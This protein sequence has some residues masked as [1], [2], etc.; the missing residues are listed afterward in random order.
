MCRHRPA[1]T[2]TNRNVPKARPTKTRSESQAK[3][4][5]PS[6]SFIQIPKKPRG[7]PDLRSVRCIA[8][9]ADG[10][11]QLISL[12]DEAM[13]IVNFYYT[14]S[15]QHTMSEEDAQ[16]KALETISKLRY[17]KDGYFSVNNSQSVMLMHPFKPEMVGK[18]MS[19]FKDPDGDNLF[20]DIVNAA[21]KEGGGF[22]RSE[23]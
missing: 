12:V 8:V 17:G 4:R 2:T 21:N 22:V 10:R 6:R 23:E 15:Q 7:I 14:A 13:S 16:K 9:N 3:N 19:G 18:N 5:S 1:I 20:T 11:E